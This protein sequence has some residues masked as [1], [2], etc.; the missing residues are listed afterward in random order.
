MFLHRVYCLTAVRRVISVC[1]LETAHAVCSHL[2]LKFLVRQT[3]IRR[4]ARLTLDDSKAFAEWEVTGLA[5]NR[6]S[7]PPA[8]QRCSRSNVDD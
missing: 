5:R 1:T 3:G 4:G 2:T 8:T 6:G 7:C